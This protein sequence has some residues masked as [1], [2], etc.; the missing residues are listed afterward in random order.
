M[1]IVSLPTSILTYRWAFKFQWSATCSLSRQIHNHAP[2]V[3]IPQFSSLSTYLAYSHWA[4]SSMD[5]LFDPGT[6]CR[7]EH[8]H[9]HRSHVPWTTAPLAFTWPLGPDSISQP[10]VREVGGLSNNT[11]CRCGSTGTTRSHCDKTCDSAQPRFRSIQ[12]CFSRSRWWCWRNGGI[13]R[14]WRCHWVGFA[15]G[16]CYFPNLTSIS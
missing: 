9:L 4:P 5:S 3:T 13:L 8:P 1:L 7:R 14:H 6:L 12:F 16:G 2:Q 10:I 11:L 15:I